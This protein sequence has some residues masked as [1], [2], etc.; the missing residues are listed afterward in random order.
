MLRLLV[1]ERR[2]PL[3][4]RPIAK[5]PALPVL[6]NRHHGRFELKSI[7]AEIVWLFIPREAQS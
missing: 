1:I 3:T 7:R 2:A 5:C 6:K 4:L